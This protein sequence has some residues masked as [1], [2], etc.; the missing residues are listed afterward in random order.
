MVLIIEVSIHLGIR[1]KMDNKPELPVVVLRKLLPH[2]R[3]ADMANVEEAFKA[4]PALYNEFSYL[5]KKHCKKTY[6]EGKFICPF[7]LVRGDNGTP[8]FKIQNSF[9]NQDYRTRKAAKESIDVEEVRHN[10]WL[11]YKIRSKTRREIQSKIVVADAETLDEWLAPENKFRMN[12][13]YWMEKG[14]K[15]GRTQQVLN[16]IMRDMELFHNAHDL[17]EHVER[18]HHPNGHHWRRRMIDGMLWMDSH[19]PVRAYELDEISNLIMGKMFNGS[20][21]RKSPRENRSFQE[22]IITKIS[23]NKRRFDGR[24][25]YMDPRLAR[26]TDI[27]YTHTYMRTLALAYQIDDNLQRATHKH[28]LVPEDLHKIMALR[29]YLNCSCEIYENIKFVDLACYDYSKFGM[30][31]AIR[32]ILDAVIKHPY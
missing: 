6:P 30:L 9:Y 13:S 15:I 31:N 14:L 11:H 5:T 7:C 10:G 12:T 22:T 27:G 25:R 1:V 32:M 23:R 4:S 16:I 24:K 18:T 21:R 28:R 20:L 29:D 17:V 19:K 8:W 3:N 2:I 26:Y